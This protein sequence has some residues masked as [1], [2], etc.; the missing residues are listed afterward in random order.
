[1]RGEIDQLGLLA[2][3]LELVDFGLVGGQAILEASAANELTLD[4]AVLRLTEELYTTLLNSRL[5][6]CTCSPPA[7]RV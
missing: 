7:A 3:L 2:T 4:A 5:S 6:G 1:M